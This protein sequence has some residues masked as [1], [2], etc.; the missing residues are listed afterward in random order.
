MTLACGSVTHS[1]PAPAAT[2]V[3]SVSAFREPTQDPTSSETNAPNS[4]DVIAAMSAVDRHTRLL[5]AGQIDAAFAM[6][7]PTAQQHWGLLAAFTTDQTAFFR[8]V[9]GRYVAR[10]PKLEEQGTIAEWLPS[11]YGATIDLRHA[12]LV[13]VDY[14]ALAGNNAGF[15]LYVVALSGTSAEMYDVR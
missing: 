14:P 15:D 11:T 6:L 8:S 7:G 1:A 9:A 5:I 4:A 13:E 12:V 10:L 3:A 2:A